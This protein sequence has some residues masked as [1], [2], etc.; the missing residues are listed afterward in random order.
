MEFNNS[1]LISGYCP[2]CKNYYVSIKG[3]ILSSHPNQYNPIS[4]MEYL[5]G[6]IKELKKRIEQA[7]ALKETLEEKNM[8]NEEK[9]AF[10]E[11]VKK[12]ENLF[13]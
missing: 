6:G 2:V 1:A 3:H 12:Y 8:T 11:M 13:K 7:K 4:L 10:N 5:S 9:E